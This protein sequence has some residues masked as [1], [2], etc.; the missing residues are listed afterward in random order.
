[1]K[2]VLDKIQELYRASSVGNGNPKAMDLKYDEIN[3]DPLGNKYDL[4]EIGP[5][6]LVTP[7]SSVMSFM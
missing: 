4:S 3:G 6:E 5:N 1:M 7:E 2:T